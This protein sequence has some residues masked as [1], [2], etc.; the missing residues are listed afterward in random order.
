ML[1]VRSK[2]QVCQTVNKLLHATAC[3]VAYLAIGGS[4]LLPIAAPAA[5]PVH[6]MAFWI[7]L[8]SAG[9]KVPAGSS[10]EALSSELF[11]MLLSTD[12]VRRDDIAY[13]AF[14]AWVHRDELL[15]PTT[16]ETL[17]VRFV[18][19]ARVGLGDAKDDRV[20]GRSFAVLCL[21][22]LAAEDLRKPFLTDSGYRELLGLGLEALSR[23]RDLR[24]YVPGKGWAHATA[25]AADLL[26]FLARNSALKSDDA[27][28]IVEGIANRL[29]TAGQVFLWGEDV[30]LAMALRSLIARSDFNPT[31]ITQWAARLQ[32]DHEAVWRGDFE[33]S[34]Y[35]AVRAQLNTLAQLGARLCG[36]AVDAHAAAVCNTLGRLFAASD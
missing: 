13:E 9:F 24:G 25:H 4:A 3:F 32:L 27:A 26:K 1:P 15:G 7:S 34:R 22:V 30:R 8:K 14:A 17:R 33:A 28:H 18:S 29:R 31:P 20:F 19:M 35:V 16:L 11:D 6:D 5:E 23:E 2:R 21:S 10:A 36:P 12:P